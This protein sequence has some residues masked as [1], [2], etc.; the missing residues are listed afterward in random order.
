MY[1]RYSLMLHLKT[2]LYFLCHI[3]LSLEHPPGQPPVHAIWKWCVGLAWLLATIFPVWQLIWYISYMTKPTG[4]I[5][6]SRVIEESCKDFRPFFFWQINHHQLCLK[7]ENS[8]LCL[9]YRNL[10]YQVGTWVKCEVSSKDG[11]MEKEQGKQ[12]YGNLLF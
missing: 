1:V 9:S 6:G 11:A 7:K 12:H 5:I 4:P 2:Q 10:V 8:H 3:T